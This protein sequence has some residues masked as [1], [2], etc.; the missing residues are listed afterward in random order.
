MTKSKLTILIPCHNEETTIGDVISQVSLLYPDSEIVVVDNASSDRTGEIA[1]SLFATVVFESQKGKG[2]AV[3]R[4]LSTIKSGHIIIIDGDSTY[5]VRD[6]A[7]IVDYLSDGFDLVVAN[8]ISTAPSAYRRNHAIG[9]VLFSKLQKNLLQVDVD[10]V[11]S[12]YR[13]FTAAFAQSIDFMSEGFEIETDLN[14]HAVVIGARVKNFDSKYDPRP[15]FSV[16]KLNTYRDGF[17]ILLAMLRLL[18]KWRP[19]LFLGVPGYS[20]AC[21]AAVLFTVPYFEY[22][23]TGKVS[24]IPTLVVSMSGLLC[25]VLL[26]LAGSIGQRVVQSSRESS[27][28]AFKLLRI[29]E[30]SN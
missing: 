24:H 28:H 8:R 3:I 26:V 5:D 22:L 13:G 11:F 15:E 4:G 21:L 1:E 2:Y 7:K 10:D 9:N 30:H 12:G 18:R 19:F 17:L 29:L 20:I 27:R 25:G 16:S 23:S 6:I 14:M